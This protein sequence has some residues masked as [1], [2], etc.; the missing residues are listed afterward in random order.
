VLVEKGRR[1]L[2]NGRRAIEAGRKKRRNVEAR[3]TAEENISVVA[4]D[5]VGATRHSRTRTAI[6][7]WASGPTGCKAID[8]NCSLWRLNSGAKGAKRR[9][10]TLKEIKN[11]QRVHRGRIWLSDFE[12]ESVV[13]TERLI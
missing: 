6:A 9:S 5:L 12:S 13:G 10:Y 4:R 8:G 7:S 3:S 2:Y 11:W 1:V